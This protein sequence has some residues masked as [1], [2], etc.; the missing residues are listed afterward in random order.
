M[1][2][3]SSPRLVR[4]ARAREYI[5]LFRKLLEQLHSNITGDFGLAR[6]VRSDDPFSK[7]EEETKIDLH[8]GDDKVDRVGSSGMFERHFNHSLIHVF[9]CEV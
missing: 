2:V 9:E 7:T 4:S 3:D 8:V 5:T 6:S 1:S